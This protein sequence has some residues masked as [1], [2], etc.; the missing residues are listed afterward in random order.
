MKLQIAAGLLVAA[1]LGFG[2]TSA[3]A[4]NAPVRLPEVESAV[5]QARCIGFRVNYRS[6]KSCMR[7]NPHSPAHCNKICQS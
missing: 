6:F 4:I 7:A 3:N 5:Q 2:A 1:L